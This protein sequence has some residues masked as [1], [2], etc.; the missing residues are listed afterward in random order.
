MDDKLNQYLKDKPDGLIYDVHECFIMKD[1]NFV[2][3]T[4]TDNNG[5]K[6]AYGCKDILD[7][8]ENFN[9]LISLEGNT[10][11]A[12][13]VSDSITF[14]QFVE[15]QSDKVLQNVILHIL[16]T[17]DYMHVR[18]LVHGDAAH[19]N[20][21]VRKTS[22]PF[23]WY[24]DVKV[25]TQG[26]HPVIID[27]DEAN[28]VGKPFI[29]SLYRPFGFA[30]FEPLYDY[31]RFFDSLFIYW[32]LEDLKKS[33]TIQQLYNISDYNFEPPSIAKGVCDYFQTHYIPIRLP[34]HI[35]NKIIHMD[36]RESSETIQEGNGVQAILTALRHLQCLITQKHTE[37]ILA[38]PDWFK[39]LIGPIKI[40]IY[41]QAAKNYSLFRKS[42]CNWPIKSVA[43]FVSFCKKT[44]RQLYQPIT[45][46]V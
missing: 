45:H 32:E 39:I 34:L 18:G 13:Y 5:L 37:D 14:S 35:L 23:I 41:N 9:K 15:T 31:Y 36:S 30:I 17:F 42:Q 11:C 38:E 1:G 26:W 4:K 2:Y 3:K 43:D 24:D 21:L 8:H 29:A 28:R 46:C 12:E 22:K 33:K 10:L 25:P 27:F 44:N 16:H 20:I 6:I 19:H 40:A 7:T